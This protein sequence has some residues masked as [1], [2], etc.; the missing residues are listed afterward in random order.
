MRNHHVQF[1]I[2]DAYFPEPATILEELHGKGNLSGKVL[3]VSNGGKD[4]E[5]F[6]VVQVEGLTR[7]V[8]VPVGRIRDLG[9]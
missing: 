1:Q 8:I 3:D 7:P 2:G 5:P 6:A 4:G 9:E